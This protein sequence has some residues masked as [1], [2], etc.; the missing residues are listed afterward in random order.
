MLYRKF[1]FVS[2]SCLI[3]WNGFEF[4]LIGLETTFFPRKNIILCFFVSQKYEI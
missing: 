2:F 1:R 3:V 4:K